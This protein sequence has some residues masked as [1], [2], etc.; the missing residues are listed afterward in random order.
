VCGIGVTAGGLLLPAGALWLFSESG[1]VMGL[2]Q[3]A[4]ALLLGALAFGL[5][6]LRETRL[7]RS[8]EALSRCWARSLRREAIP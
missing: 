2:P 7:R 3:V 1:F 4:A 6:Q 8:L 5:A